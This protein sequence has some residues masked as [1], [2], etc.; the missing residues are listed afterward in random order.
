[1]DSWSCLSLEGCLTEYSTRLTF[2]TFILCVDGQISSYFFPVKI[3]IPTI[4]IYYKRHFS[5]DGPRWKS[6]TLAWPCLPVL[7]VDISMILH[8]RFFNITWPFLR[9]AEHCCGYL[10]KSHS[11]FE[12]ENSGRK[13]YVADAPASPVVK[14]SSWS[15]WTAL[16]AAV[17]SA[18][19]VFKIEID[20]K[21]KF[22]TR[23]NAFARQMWLSTSEKRKHNMHQQKYF[24][25]RT[26]RNNT[27]QHVA[28]KMM[29][30]LLR[31]RQCC[32]RFST[33]ERFCSSGCLNCNYH[34]KGFY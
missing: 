21:T 28:I 23:Q 33:F 5:D 29:I 11:E 16:A 8:G 15:S 4:W 24:M 12:K 7:D 2:G 25:S 32:L 13:T 1:M 18:I 27:V 20:Q 19:L 34:F 22:S 10:R 9:K 6:F 14:S 3:S 31:R 26:L 17:F 30:P